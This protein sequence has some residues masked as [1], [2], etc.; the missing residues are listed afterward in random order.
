MS[1]DRRDSQSH[2]RLEQAHGR[3]E[4]AADADGDPAALL[5]QLLAVAQA[6]ERA[7]DSAH[8]LH[9]ARQ[10]A[11]APLL[12]LALVTSRLAPR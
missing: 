1:R 6:H 4:V 9:D 12:L 10:V 11:D 3:A 5:E 2:V 7:I 8:H